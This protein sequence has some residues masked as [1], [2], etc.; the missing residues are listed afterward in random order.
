M[1]LPADERHIWTT[2]EADDKRVG[3]LMAEAFQEP[4]ADWLV[5]DPDARAEIHPIF[6]RLLAEDARRA[7]VVEV[8]GDFEAAALW[9]DM[10]Q[11]LAEGP[12]GVD[13]RFEEA[14]GPYVERWNLAGEVMDSEHPQMPHHYLLAIGVRPDL[15]GRGVGSVLLTHHHEL[16]RGTGLTA[17]LDATTLASRA[18]YQRHGYS[19]F[20]AP[21]QVPDG[22]IIYP[23]LRPAEPQ[24]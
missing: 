4:L 13:P 16:L 18:L 2:T 17:Y 3:A 12:G 21:L 23:M 1:T 15:Q 24:R 20:V 7:G 6:F 10:S 11:P 9:F 19:D 22:P 14:M 5:P 8:Y